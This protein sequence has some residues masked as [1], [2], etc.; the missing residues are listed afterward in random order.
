ML[1]HFGVSRFAVLCERKKKFQSDKPAR[2]LNGCRIWIC[3]RPRCFPRHV[4]RFGA[5]GLCHG[6]SMPA[7]EHAGSHRDGEPFVGVAGYRICGI[8]SGE[9]MSENRR[10]GG[11]AA[12]CCIH[13][14]P[15][16]PL[17]TKTRQVW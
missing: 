13:M 4:G 10:D 7:E 5:K 1:D 9:V 6:I 8:N 15:Q 11:S 3:N 2:P 17:L 16:L 14:K 12:P